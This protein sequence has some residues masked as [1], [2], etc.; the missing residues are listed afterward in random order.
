M[1]QDI[2][3]GRCLQC[4]LYSWNTSPFNETSLDSTGF[5]FVK[6]LE[7]YPDQNETHAEPEKQQNDLRP[8]IKV[9]RAP[10]QAFSLPDELP[11][12]HSAAYILRSKQR[13]FE[14]NFVYCLDK[15][16]AP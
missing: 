9:N 16:T 1:R 2:G 7:S 3:V 13:R 15:R 12:E 14:V 5:N 10:R 11:V 4:L 6:L 8:V